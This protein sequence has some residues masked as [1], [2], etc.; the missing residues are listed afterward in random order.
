MGRRVLTH[1][2]V[3][4]ELPGYLLGEFDG[5]ACTVLEAHLARCPRCRMEYDR[6]AEVLGRLGTLA[7]PAAPPPELRD[8]VLAQLDETAEPRPVFR[9]PVRPV[10]WMR[11]LLVA[12]AVIVLVMGGSL[13][14]LYR[15]LDQT[16]AALAAERSRDAEARGILAE[17][18]ATIPLVA[19]SGA[20]AYGTLYLAPDGSQAVMVIDKIPP[21][22]T[23]R[24]YQ[25]WLVQNGQRTSAGL[26]TVGGDSRTQLL[27]N[28]PKPLRSY[29]SLGITVEPAPHG[30]SGPTTPKVIGCPLGN[31]T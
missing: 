27:L 17:P 13:A 7:A 25:V 24:V 1:E 15:D 18:S 14:Y 12:A 2:E 9:Q 26:F 22:P 28:A 5:G 19:G 4:D 16:R 20:D 3:L 31:T 23:G 30:S 11:P 6:Q 8:R 10:R 21:P 29:Q